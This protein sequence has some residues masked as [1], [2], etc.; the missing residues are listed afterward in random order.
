MTCKILIHHQV[1]ANSSLRCFPAHYQYNGIFTVHRIQDL[2][3]STIT[4]QSSDYSQQIHEGMEAP[5]HQT[6]TPHFSFGYH[7]EQHSLS[8][9]PS[10][11]AVV[12]Y[13]CCGGPFTTMNYLIKLRNKIGP[14]LLGRK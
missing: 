13:K 11:T 10:K 1:S 9:K 5:K 12:K 4:N 6:V 14:A 7:P 2:L 3:K 8:Q